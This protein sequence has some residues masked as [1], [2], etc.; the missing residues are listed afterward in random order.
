MPDEEQIS[1]SIEDM[2]NNEVMAPI[3]GGAASF[4][5]QLW[6]LNAKQG[7]SSINRLVYGWIVRN[8]HVD[9][10]WQIEDKHGR[11]KIADTKYKV[12]T[13]NI[14]LPQDKIKAVL[15]ALVA[16]ESITNISTRLTLDLAKKA[17]KYQDFKLDSQ[18]T[19]RPPA[20]LVARNHM[21]RRKS[22]GLK[23]PYSEAGAI[24]SG[25]CSLSAASIFE[26]N[27]SFSRPLA[28]YLSDCVNQDTGLNLLGEDVSR[29]GMLE[30]F[31]SPEL[32]CFGR[33]K[34]EMD[35]KDDKVVVD[36]FA[37]SGESWHQLQFIVTLYLDNVSVRT[38]AKIVPFNQS[39]VQVCL[40][41]SD[42]YDGIG[43]EVFG[44]AMCQD[45]Q[46]TPIVQWRRNMLM[47]ANIGANVVSSRYKLQHDWLNKMPT[48]NKEEDRVEKASSFTK[49][50]RLAPTVV[51]ELEGPW[52]SANEQLRAVIDNAFP[53]PSGAL[54]LEKLRDNKNA[55]LEL[56]EWLKALFEQ[57]DCHDFEVFDPYWD[58]SASVLI[59]AYLPKGASLTVYTDDGK[60]R[61]DN[62]I[63]GFKRY[64]A[65]VQWLQ[66][67]AHYTIKF[68][69]RSTPKRA[70][71][72]DR[73]LLITDKTSKKVTAG[74][75]LSNSL[76]KANENYPLLI[77]PIPADILIDVD[78]YRQGLIKPG[79]TEIVLDSSTSEIYVDEVPSILPQPF[80]SLDEVY[81]CIEKC[82]ENNLDECMQHIGKCLY[83]S[84]DKLFHVESITFSASIEAKLTTFLQNRK[85]RLVKQ[86][87]IT[88]QLLMLSELKS[89]LPSL[90]AHFEYFEEMQTNPYFKSK[91]LAAADYFALK[92]L[93]RGTPLT[94]IAMIQGWIEDW[95]ED[96]N[97][98]LKDYLLAYVF[99]TQGLN[100]L[101]R[102]QC[103]DK[104]AFDI[105]T[106]LASQN[107][108]LKW[109]AFCHLS[110]LLSEKSITVSDIGQLLADEDN[111]QFIGWQLAKA[112]PTD[113]ASQQEWFDPL[114]TYLL[115]EVLP[116][117]LERK[118]LSALFAAFGANFGRL[119]AWL[120]NQLM[121]PLQK[122]GRIEFDELAELWL[123][124]QSRL[125]ETFGSDNRHSS[126]ALKVTGMV[127]QLVAQAGEEVQRRLLSDVEKQLK[128][129]SRIIRKNL[130]REINY[131]SW[132]LALD[133]VLWLFGAVNWTVY[134]MNE[135]KAVK[136]DFLAMKLELEQL[137]A[138][139]SE[140][141]WQTRVDRL[142]KMPGIMV[143]YNDFKSIENLID[144]IELPKINA[145]S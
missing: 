41:V 97:D 137:L 30:V 24:S 85:D 65:L 128:P 131:Q 105:S 69:K 58:G 88:N 7:T 115:D 113:K 100:Q 22:V 66:T 16:G 106:L 101:F 59:S 53:K 74:F 25:I 120:S 124:E 29:I 102:A 51:G 37:E 52:R 50:D 15:A 90:L 84:T 109:F 126:V 26:V 11:L 33:E 34:V 108:F 12:V 98:E 80:S 91:S 99:I 44:N 18:F 68:I 134:L 61:R 62:R 82:S 17:Q 45:S 56:V 107:S 32:D 76:Q 10:T 114:L 38:F 133:L 5:L 79:A 67:G 141:K 117:R 60:D 6:L 83:H 4:G 19:I 142:S 71:I 48:G 73:Y 130:S 135:N 136:A 125:W 23:S 27:G 36:Y 31:N 47:Q 49:V 8:D 21:H 77:T 43:L 75:N 129:L 92:L 94:L 143:F 123:D 103:F 139:R 122:A 70:A 13:L 121:V 81:T 64:N 63:H 57:Y 78:T 145:S 14:S 95:I 127:V 104:A 87:D 119:N 20:N 2:I 35:C 54:F 40:Q 9:N 1:D 144:T 39:A 111:I 89:E 86:T 3:F 138:Y 93:A 28:S 132:S 140:Q 72:H 55:R 42:S 46:V 96:N 118:L 112:N 116:S 110:A